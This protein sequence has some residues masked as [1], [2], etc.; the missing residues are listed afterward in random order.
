[1]G[2]DREKLYGIIGQ[3]MFIFGMIG[4]AMTFT[5]VQVLNATYHIG[6]TTI[7]FQGFPWDTKQIGGVCLIRGG[8]SSPNCSF[9]NYKYLLEF[10]IV[11]SMIGFAGWK[12][13]RS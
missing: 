4:F 10:S 2:I 11:S 6:N 12:Y 5:E 13:F 7:S 9:P 8:L 3:C 1:M